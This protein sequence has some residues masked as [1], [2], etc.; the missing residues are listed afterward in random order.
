MIAEAAKVEGEAGSASV[1]RA[2]LEITVPYRLRH[3]LA[4]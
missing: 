1:R 2:V 3:G 4:M